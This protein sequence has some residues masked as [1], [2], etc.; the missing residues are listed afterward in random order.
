MS[1]SIGKRA[2]ARALRSGAIA[3]LMLSAQAHATDGQ[4][5]SVLTGYE[6]GPAGTSLLAGDYESVMVRLGGHSVLFKRDA[7]AASTN[8]CVAYIMSRAWDA[9]H[10]ACDE[11][12]ALARLDASSFLPHSHKDRDQEVAIAYSNRAVL[13]RLRAQPASAAHDIAKARALAPQVAGV[14]HNA[15]VFGDAKSGGLAVAAARE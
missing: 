10:A 11:A 15:A 8:L 1:S 3:A 13:Y 12:L 6:D 7:V 9:A 2:A 14:A 5:K 4:H